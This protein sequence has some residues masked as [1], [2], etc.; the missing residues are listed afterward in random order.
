[1]AT[2][3]ELEK[4]V[5][6]LANELATL[7]SRVGEKTHILSDWERREVKKGLADRYATAR[8]VQKVLAKYGLQNTL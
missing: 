7:R 4:K 6:K 3:A 5:T 2:V 1:M 8:E